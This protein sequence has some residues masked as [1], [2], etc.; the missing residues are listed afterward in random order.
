[1]RGCLAAGLLKRIGLSELITSSDNEYIDLVVRLAQDQKYH[2]EV[3][4]K[5]I[6]NRHLLYEDTSVVR[7][8]ENFLI[9]QLRSN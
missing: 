4:A 3:E 6:K 9:S 7:F 5:I 1:M 2:N 8:L